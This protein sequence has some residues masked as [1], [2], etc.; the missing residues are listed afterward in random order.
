M[1][2]RYI[3]VLLILLFSFSLSAC[4][5]NLHS[6]EKKESVKGKDTVLVWKD[7]FVIG[8]YDDGN[9]LSVI[10]EGFSENV[11]KQ[12]TI[13][14]IIDDKLYVVSNEGYAIID[15][16]CECRVNV[17]VPDNEFVREYSADEYGNSLYTSRY[18]EKENIIYLAHFQ[19]FSDDEQRMFK[20]IIS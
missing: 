18:L 8:H 1:N 11:L 13:Y 3:F 7:T 12:V 9:R 14:K 19:D 6:S 16:N 4:S 15:K 17:T 2:K 10:T 20:K 5:N